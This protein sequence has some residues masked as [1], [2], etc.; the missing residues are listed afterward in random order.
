MFYNKTMN[1]YVYSIYILLKMPLML[2]KDYIYWIKNT[3]KTS[4]IVKYYYNLK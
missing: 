3:L 1:E 2:T 4:N